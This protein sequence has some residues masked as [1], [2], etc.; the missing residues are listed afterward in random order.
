MVQS[1]PFHASTNGRT[2]K[3]SGEYCPTAMQN[4][5]EV[6]DTPLRLLEIDGFTLGTVDQSAPFQCRIS[7]APLALPTAAQSEV[8]THDTEFNPVEYTGSGLDSIVHDEGVAAANTTPLPAAPARQEP[9]TRRAASPRPV[10]KIHRFVPRI[11]FIPASPL[12]GQGRLYS[13]L[14]TT[15]AMPSIASLPTQLPT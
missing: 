5:A 3:I 13:E 8:P 2:E 4:L 1:I 6:H 7:V 11:L 10:L 15:R 9:T 14:R 12:A